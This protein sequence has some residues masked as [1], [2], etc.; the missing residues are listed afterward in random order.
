MRTDLPTHILNHPKIIHD[1][2]PNVALVVQNPQG[3]LLWCERLDW[4]GSWQFPQGGVDPGE[5]PEDAM[6]R[7]GAEELGL[8]PSQHLLQISK[9]LPSPIR[10][11]FTQEIIEGFLNQGRPSY[12]GQAQYYFLLRFLGQDADI[13]LTPPPGFDAHKEFSRFQWAG[14]ELATQ[15]SPFKRAAYQQ[16]LS[17]L[18]LC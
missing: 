14:P 16:A 10:Y 7:E 3:L 9:A 8:L 13:T 6:W 17:A 15:V 11:D 5:S 18:G 12:I 1:Y 4:P 2:R